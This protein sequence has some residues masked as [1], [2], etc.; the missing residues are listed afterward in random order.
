[1]SFTH[2]RMNH[3]N[4]TTIIDFAVIGLNAFL[5]L[6]A[7]QLF[8]TMAIFEHLNAN[9]ITSILGILWIILVRLPKAVYYINKTVL[10]LRDTLRGKKLNRDEYLKD[11]NDTKNES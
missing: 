5:G 6:F 7:V 3:N 1:M 10:G 2:L 4:T 8:Q 9:V 11:D